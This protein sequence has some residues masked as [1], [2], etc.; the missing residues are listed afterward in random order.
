MENYRNILLYDGIHDVADLVCARDR[1]DLLYVFDR[2]RDTTDYLSALFRND[3]GVFIFRGQLDVDM[4][5]VAPGPLPDLLRGT[6]RNGELYLS[7]LLRD[8]IARNAAAFEGLAKSGLLRS[9][10]WRIP[11]SAARTGKDDPERLVEGLDRIFP[12][13]H[14]TDTKRMTVPGGRPAF[15]VTTWDFDTPAAHGE[16][17]TPKGKPPSGHRLLN[18]VYAH[19]RTEDI[20]AVNRGNVSVVWSRF[21]VEG[22]DLHLYLNAYSF[23]GRTEGLD[24][25]LLSEPVIVLPGQYNDDIWQ[26]FDHVITLYDHLIE[27]RPGFSKNL[28]PR[29]GL[30]VSTDNADAASTADP[31]ERQQK[32]PLEERLRGMMLVNGNKHSRV[33]GELYSKRIE[34]ALW[35][36]NNSDLPF[37]VYGTPPFLLPN[38]RGAIPVGSRLATVARYR[39][40]LC[41]ENTDH[42]VLSLGY[43]E[44]ILDC[45]ETRTVPVYLG[46]P[47]IGRY[48]PEDCYI[49]FRRFRDYGELDS[50]LRSMTDDEYLRYV[51]NIDTWVASGGLSHYTWESLYNRMAGCY[52]AARGI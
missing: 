19:L 5:Q 43:V 8:D 48:I 2:D 29:S 44:K 18:V 1:C 37:H 21:P 42:P 16:N 12:G 11:A 30:N 50:Y 51:E 40:C 9:I 23:A 14:R 38:Y 6:S 7:I 26:H 47:N 20:H 34:A 27:T 25:L 17:G 24:V 33:P 10:E 41:F 31:F 4:G 35:F 52:A 22:S 45:M 15:T 3:A 46:A 13:G 28:Y 32:Y 49:D 39:Y 36:H